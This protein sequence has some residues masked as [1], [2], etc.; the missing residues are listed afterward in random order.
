M[1]NMTK[2]YDTA[3]LGIA[4]SGAEISPAGYLALQVSMDARISHRLLM[5]DY[6]SKHPKILD[7]PVRRPIFVIGFPRTGTTFLHDMLGLHPDCSSHKLWEQMSPIPSS[8]NESIAARATDRKQRYNG[9]ARAMF[10]M[11]LL[12]TDPAIQHIHRIEY[13]A[14]EGW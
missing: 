3:L 8:H 4:K 7:I 12:T 13:D 1:K 11:T 2:Q 5:V 10:R 9:A 14:P 6:L